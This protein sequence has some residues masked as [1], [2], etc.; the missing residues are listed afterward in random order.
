MKDS[1]GKFKDSQEGAKNRS[2]SGIKKGQ[3]SITKKKNLEGAT[4]DV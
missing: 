4:G 2:V 1:Q 3:Q